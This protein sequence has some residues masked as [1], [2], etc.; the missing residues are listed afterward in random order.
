MYV[1]LTSDKL[2]LLRFGTFGFPMSVMLL[3]FFFVCCFCFCFV[4]LHFVLICFILFRFILFLFDFL[5]RFISFRFVPLCLEKNCSTY[6]NGAADVA[7]DA[8]RG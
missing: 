1:G 4:V 6:V 5:F 2:V 8:F 7:L 3:L